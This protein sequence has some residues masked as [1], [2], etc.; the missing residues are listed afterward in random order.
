MTR[1]LALIGVLLLSFACDSSAPK[2]QT[3]VAR[4]NGEPVAI[5]PLTAA[6]SATPAAAR[7]KIDLAIT[8]HLAA[9]EAV[10]RGLTNGSPSTA[11]SIKDEERLRDALFASMRDSLE[12][13]EPELRAH[14]EKTKLR[15]ASRQVVLRRKPFASEAEARAAD[16]Q[17]GA[18]GRLTG[19]GSETLGPA[20]VESLPASVL[21]EALSLRAPGQRAAVQ[22]EG[23]WAL[24][25]L[26]EIRASESLPLESVRAQV[27]QSLRL[28]RAQAA[29]HAELE[30]L[31]SEADIEIGAAGADAHE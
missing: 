29:F 25:E 2:Q 7:R 20:P 19:E 16:R 31:R 22:R 5:A 9:G 15:Y 6:D 18:T 4:V 14:Y 17:L 1:W 10:R 27:E 3:P 12:L 11:L 26:A 24:V 21:P 23:R 8:R 13:N 30:R 28:I